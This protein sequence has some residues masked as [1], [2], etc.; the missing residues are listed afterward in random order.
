M[1]QI[2]DL[3]T[4]QRRSKAQLKSQVIAD[5]VNEMSWILSQPPT[6]IGARIRPEEDLANELGITRRMVRQAIKAFTDKGVLVRR[7]G[8]G[9]YVRRVHS[10]P[11]DAA[12]SSVFGLTHEHLFLDLQT[13]DT[14]TQHLNHELIGKAVQSLRIG[15][16]SDWQLSPP[17]TT[18][19]VVLSMF[20]RHA[21]LAGHTMTIHSQVTSSQKA[22]PV[23][24]MAKQLE[25]ASD[26]GFLVGTQYADTF[27]KA[28]KMA[29]SV[30]PYLFHSMGSSDF[31]L[32]PS[33]YVDT[34]R[35]C[36]RALQ[37][38]IELDYQRIGT[39]ALHTTKQCDI[40]HHVHR[41]MMLRANLCQ[42]FHA[43]A[44]DMGVASSMQAT[45]ELLAKADRKLD[46]IY[47]TNDMVLVGVVEALKLEKLI[48]GKDIAII[49]LANRGYPLP[50]GYNWS[51]MMFDPESYASTTIRLISQQ[52]EHPDMPV[53]SMAI[54][55][56]YIE[57]DT[58]LL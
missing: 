32:H 19:H 31:D 44:H 53:S 28:R 12:E 3:Q 55:A 11:A 40:E 24:E 13:T 17:H 10:H 1:P 35:A 18:T 15:L 8:S 57:G 16:W 37:H 6:C 47:V 7:Q 41:G 43:Y 2:I 34:E 20:M 42:D 51:K 48:P 14:K 50:R 39:I 29:G 56:T 33:I 49:T 52:I 58:H 26:D 9:T 4:R 46:A 5:L 30:C 22:L 45:R 36:Q 23:Q 54:Q 27:L 21:Q 38:L 25:H